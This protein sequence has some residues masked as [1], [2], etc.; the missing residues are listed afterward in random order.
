MQN[1]HQGSIIWLSFDPQTG[2]EESK[3]RPALIISGNSALSLIKG[4]A[5]V[6]PITS[7]SREFPTH[8]LLDGRTKTQGLILCEQAKSLDLEARNAEFIEK[9]PDDIVQEAVNIVHSLLD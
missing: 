1:F 8:V 9:A 3:R 4:I 6:C 7:H 2:H 5:M